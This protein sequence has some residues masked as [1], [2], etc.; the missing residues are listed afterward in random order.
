MP[1]EKELVE[2]VENF[3]NEEDREVGFFAVGVID[4]I[5]IDE[6]KEAFCGIEVISYTKSDLEFKVG[7][8]SYMLASST[9]YDRWRVYKLIKLC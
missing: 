1:S 5:V 2:E 6:F 8:D 3:F 9:A 7:N 4:K